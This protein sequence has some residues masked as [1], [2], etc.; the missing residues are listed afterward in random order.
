MRLDWFLFN[1]QTS[2]KNEMDEFRIKTDVQKQGSDLE[3][4]M[5]AKRS[6]TIEDRVI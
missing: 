4:P 5:I 2:Q 3:M 6:G 1:K